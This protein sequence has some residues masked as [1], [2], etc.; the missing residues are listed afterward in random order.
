M[1]AS[2][3]ACNDVNFVSGDNY[4]FSIHKIYYGK[5][6][7]Q[8]EAV[9][10]HFARARKAIVAGK[11]AVHNAVDFCV[12]F[13]RRRQNDNAGQRKSELSVCARAQSDCKK[14]VYH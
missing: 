9:N 4:H 11:D 2:D 5:K 8:R 3:Y 12:S 1:D 6:Y 14:S 13:C 7:S 10:Y